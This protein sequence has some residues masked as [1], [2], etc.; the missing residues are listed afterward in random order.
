M[1]STRSYL[2]ELFHNI[3]SHINQYSLKFGLI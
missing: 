2:G 3:Y 1:K